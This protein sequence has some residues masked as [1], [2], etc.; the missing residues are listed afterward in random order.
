MYKRDLL[1]GDDKLKG[2]SKYVSSEVQSRTDWLLAQLIRIFEAPQSVVEFT[3]IGPED[4]ALA[5]QQTTAVNWIMRVKNSHLSYLHPWFQNSII[6]G[7]GVVTAEFSTE[8]EESLPRV[9][10]GVPN[11]QLIALNQQEEAGQIIIESASKPYSHPALPGVEL[12]DLKIR[13]VRKNPVFNILSVP[14]EDFVVSKDARFS[15]ET[16]GIEAKLQGHR[17]YVSRQALIDM[18]YDAEKVNAIPL[19][20]DKSERPSHGTNKGPR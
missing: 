20:S 7:L 11:E 19:A 10:K 8:I 9:V 15:S 18:G 17:K 16:G 6:S 3:G 13:T 1:A 5:K 12:R 2:R 4:S 14:P